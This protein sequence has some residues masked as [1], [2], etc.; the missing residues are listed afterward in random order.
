MLSNRAGFQHDVLLEVF[1]SF[2]HRFQFGMVAGGKVRK[3]AYFGPRQ[4]GFQAGN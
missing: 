4:C 1:V 2:L 3:A